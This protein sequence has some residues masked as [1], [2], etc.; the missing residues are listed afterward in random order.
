M[1]PPQPDYL[2]AAV[3]LQ[4][5]RPPD[6]LLGLAHSVEQRLGRERHERWGARTLDADILWI[7]GVTV[8]TD[9]L[10]VPHRGLV[11]RPFAL[12]PL[13]E[14]VPDARDPVTGTPLA[15]ALAGLGPVSA[16]PPTDLGAG[17]P[18]ERIDHDAGTSVVVCAR[19][20]ADLLAAAAEAL[21][22][23]AIES[24]G[25]ALASTTEIRVSTRNESWTDA[26][27]MSAWLSEVIDCVKAR[28]FVV[29]RVVVLADREREVRGVLL[30]EAVRSVGQV[31]K[32]VAWQSPQVSAERGNAWRAEIVTERVG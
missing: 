8:A 10:T 5:E 15:N 20:R 4:T 19:D 29:R 14:L 6:E 16:D 9:V 2:N 11:N 25:A 26:Q 22:A 21:C 32:S 18:I 7:E 3:L 31:G 24:Q 1:G 23:S 28:S 27:R 30:G 12:V 13:L 17:F